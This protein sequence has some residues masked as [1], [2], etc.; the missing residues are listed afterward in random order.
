MKKIFRIQNDGIVTGLWSDELVGLGK[1]KV[2]RASRVEFQE[3]RGGWSVEILIG[4]L[5]N[6]CLAKIFQRRKDA[7][8]AEVEV[9]N[10]QIIAGALS[11]QE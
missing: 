2:T 11:F 8:A 10:E 4:P 9:L 5:K 1:T 6:S 7:L 3:K